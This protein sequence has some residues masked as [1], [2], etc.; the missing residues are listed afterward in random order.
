MQNQQGLSLRMFYNSSLTG[1]TINT[2]PYRDEKK[3]CWVGVVKKILTGPHFAHL[4]ELPRWKP[5]GQDKIS[6]QYRKATSGFPLKRD[7]EEWE[8]NHWQEVIDAQVYPKQTTIPFTF[9]KASTP[10]LKQVQTRCKGI[11]TLRYKTKLIQDIIEFW[12]QDPALPIQTIDIEDFLDHTYENHGGKKANRSLREFSTLFTWME[13]RQFISTNPITPIERYPETEFKKYVPPKTDILKIITV[14]NAFEKDLIRTAYHTLA[15]SIEIRRLKKTDC[16]FKNRKVW[17]YTRKR[18]G[19]SLD[20]SFVDMN[21]SL[22]EILRR[23]CATIESEYVFPGGDGDRLSKYTLDN[24]MPRLFKRIN[25]ED[26]Q[27]LPMERQ[28][29]SFGFHAIRHHVAAHL[30]LNCGYT[31]AEMQRILR[32]KRASTTDTYLKSIV[33]MDTTRGLSALDDFEAEQE[34]PAGQKKLI[35]YP[36]VG[37]I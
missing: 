37:D 12:G 8:R 5:H 28:T 35:A 24:V 20:G 1:I 6:F 21:D 32:H 13:K 2:M 25:S 31:V 16:D 36:S 22:Y 26:D 11:N 23:R 3:K 9:S 10:Y 27:P 29:K 30:F 15:R 34:K 7:A 4:E 19:S 17:F 33:D 14:A 18:K